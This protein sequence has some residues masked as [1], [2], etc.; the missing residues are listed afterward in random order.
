MAERGAWVW[1]WVMLGALLLPATAAADPDK[2]EA[3]ADAESDDPD[4]PPRGPSRP[5]PRPPREARWDEPFG[6]DGGRFGVALL[7]RR[8]WPGGESHGGVAIEGGQMG[9]LQ[10]GAVRLGLTQGGTLRVFGS[11]DLAAGYTYDVSS[12]VLLGPLA[13]DA[14]VGLTTLSVDHLAGQ[15]SAQLFSPRVGLGAS[16]R[17]G[18]IIVGARVFSEYNWRWFGPDDR[19]IG[20]GIDLRFLGHRYPLDWSEFTSRGGS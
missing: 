20:L 6:T 14:W 13:V 12:S 9:H 17:A 15:W 18:S 1:G 4:P 7:S 3:P 2:H 8:P 19:L 10:A 16:V 11:R 5:P